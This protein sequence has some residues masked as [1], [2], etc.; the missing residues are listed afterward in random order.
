MTSLSSGEV[1]RGNRYGEFYLRLAL[2][3]LMASFSW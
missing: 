3:V 2:L 1:S